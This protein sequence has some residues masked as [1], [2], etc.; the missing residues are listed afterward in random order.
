MSKKADLL[1]SIVVPTRANNFPQLQKLLSALQNQ[2]LQ[3]FELLLI[4]DRNFSK[5]EREEF[6]DFINQQA[7]LSP[8]IRLFSHYNSDFLPHSPGA[9][10]YV[11]NYGILQARGEFI[12]L[13]DDDNTFDQHYL[14]TALKLYKQHKKADSEAV[15]T[16]TLM[17]KDSDK[18]QNQGFSAYNYR[19]ARPQ[20]HF[21]SQGQAYGEIQMFSGNGVF[22]RAELMKK[23]LYDEKIAWIAEDLDFVYRLHKAGA[24][25]LVFA[26]LKVLHWEREK[27]ELEQAR[28]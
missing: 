23:V 26:D 1:I 9:A 4:C 25:I 20:I 10:S 6:Q 11:R 22:A 28:I 27:N 7:D 14:Q 3:D 17:R 15:I 16:P 12:Q 2:T 24:R 21:L 5:I 18:I 13:F 19:L 8:K